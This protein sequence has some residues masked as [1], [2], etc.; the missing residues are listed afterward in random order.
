M[1]TVFAAEASPSMPNPPFSGI[2]LSPPATAAAPAS[3][4]SETAANGGLPNPGS[5][6]DLFKKVKGLLQIISLT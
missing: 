1:G 6:E 5:F 3:L 4:G 2:P